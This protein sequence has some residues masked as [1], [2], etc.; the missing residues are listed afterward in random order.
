MA[1]ITDISFA[2]GRFYKEMEC[3]YVYSDRENTSNVVIDCYKGAIGFCEEIDNQ[4]GD[5]SCERACL[6][7][8]VK[9]LS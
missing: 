3:L 1:E 8:A 6:V 7:Q 2:K 4:G 9:E 5:S